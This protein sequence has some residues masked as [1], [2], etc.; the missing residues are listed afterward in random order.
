M[1]VVFS[2]AANLNFRYIYLRPGKLEMEQ[3]FSVQYCPHSLSVSDKTMP[4]IT[5]IGAE[6]WAELQ[7]LRIW[8][9][10]EAHW[11]YSRLTFG[12]VRGRNH[13][14]LVTNS[15][16]HF[17]LFAFCALDFIDFKT[18]FDLFVLCTTLNEFVMASMEINVCLQ[19]VLCLAIPTHIINIDKQFKFTVRQS[20]RKSAKGHF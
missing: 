12:G 13:Y 17:Y 16:W 2:L 20:I 8:L 3:Y 7:V 10:C 15:V 9:P 6:P 18:K 5:I 14:C 1:H 19:T 4:P 11:I